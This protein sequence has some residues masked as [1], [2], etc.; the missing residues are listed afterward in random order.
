M[1]GVVDKLTLFRQNIENWE[2]YLNDISR[3]FKCSHTPELLT[4]KNHY[5]IVDM[6]SLD[7]PVLILFHFESMK[8]AHRAMVEELHSNYSR[9]WIIGH[10]VLYK[11]RIRFCRPMEHTIGL[12]FSNYVYLPEHITDQDKKSYRTKLRYHKRVSEG[13]ERRLVKKNNNG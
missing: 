12:S 7:Q 6:R 13:L 2:A 5:Y 1:D 10:G 9:F 11:E 4:R 3:P 8:N